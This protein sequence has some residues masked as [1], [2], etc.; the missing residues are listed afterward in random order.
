M[1]KTWV[2]IVPFLSIVLGTAVTLR[3]DTSATLDAVD[4]T[5]SASDLT[6]GPSAK[7]QPSFELPTDLSYRQSP[8]HDVEED[9]QQQADQLVEDR[10][11]RAMD[12]KNP[13]VRDKLSPDAAQRLG[14]YFEDASPAD[15]PRAFL[16]YEIAA[17]KG[18]ADAQY[19]LG[20]MLEAGTGIAADLEEAATWYRLASAKGH[21][22]ATAKL[23]IFSL[24][25]L[26]GVPK[27]SEEAFAQIC[28]AA[29]ME[30]NQ[31]VA[32]SFRQI[33]TALFEESRS[34]YTHLLLA[35]TERPDFFKTRGILPA[36]I[37]STLPPRV[38]S[39]EDDQAAQDYSK[40]FIEANIPN[41]ALLI[42]Y[43]YY[44]GIYLPYDLG[45]TRK[46]LAQIADPDERALQEAIVFSV[47]GETP[48]ERLKQEAA[49]EH[50]AEYGMVEAQRVLADRFL[51][52]TAGVVD[53]Q[54]SKHF[55]N[56]W[57][58]STRGSP[59]SSFAELQERLHHKA[60]SADE[61]KIEAA[62]ASAKMDGPDRKPHTIFQ[63]RPFYPVELRYSGITGTVKMEFVVTDKGRVV[64]VK[65]TESPHPLLSAAA[66]ASVSQWRFLP[67]IKGG[68]FV[69][70]R[71]AIP[72]TF[73]LNTDVSAAHN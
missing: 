25:G 36:L 34:R 64:N 43:H 57:A 42:A 40:R 52:G 23:A 46:Y 73:N 22:L 53:L 54:K 37:F 71:V 56:L 14:K 51:R 61:A 59:V 41:S 28:R 5:P 15:L 47:A 7:P 24:K 27:N 12:P 3:A 1:R 50:M 17:Q 13:D 10:I 16:F 21:L 30:P 66:K 20:T 62:F 32:N 65:V 69:N 58:A 72:V 67:G 48:E 49:L 18:D 63:A 38:V 19:H 44:A 31:E 60:P 4:D 26:G 6:K 2:G 8:P 33:T 68:K 35:P 39:P 11:A 29:S 55:F 9:V 70:T 45:L